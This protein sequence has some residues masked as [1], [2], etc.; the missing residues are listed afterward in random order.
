MDQVA[1]IA[2]FASVMLSPCRTA[3]TVGKGDACT[4]ENEK[5]KTISH[6]VR[7]GKRVRGISTLPRRSAR[8]FSLGLNNGYRQADARRD[9]DS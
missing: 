1:E 7:A 8:Y 5:A 6:Q 3:C 2:S 4:G 9:G